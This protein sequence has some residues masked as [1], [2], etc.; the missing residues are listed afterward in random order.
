V[1]DGRSPI[2][3]RRWTAPGEVARDTRVRMPWWC[4]WWRPAG[5]DAGQEIAHGVTKSD[6]EGAFEIAFPARPDRSVDERD[7]PSFTYA[8]SA[9]CT[10]G[11]GETRSAT[12]TTVGYAALEAKIDVAGYLDGPP[13]R[14]C[15]R[16]PRS[17]DPV[18]ATGTLKVFRAQGRRVGLSTELLPPTRRATCA[19]P[20]GAS[21]ERHDR[22]KMPLDGRAFRLP[23]APAAPTAVLQTTDPS[24]GRCATTPVPRARRGGRRPG[25]IPP[26]PRRGAE[27]SRWGDLSPSWGSGHHQSAGSGGASQPLKSPTGS[28]AAPRRRSACRSRRRCAAASPCA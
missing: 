27:R 5:G 25:A 21:G 15:R 6:P 13:R 20:T 3:A 1:R 24:G 7:N 28:A 11:T 12:E 8:V 22:R 26:T 19:A 18:P 16:R 14:T 23:S 2:R 10:D 9:D 17:T 4:W